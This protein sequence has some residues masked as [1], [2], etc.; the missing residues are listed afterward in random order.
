MLNR[1][2]MLALLGIAPLAAR[3]ASATG[4]RSVIV[5]GAGL[6]GLTAA[7]ALAT[8]GHRVTVVEARDRIGG[9][10]HTSR[11]WR[12]LPMDM[13]ASWIHGT[14][15]NPLTMLADAAGARRAATSYDRATAFG[16][17]GRE[18]DLDPAMTR[19]EHL[20]ETA[21][22]AAG[23]GD[24]LASAV[25]ATQGWRKADASERRLIRH[26]VN[27]NLELEYGCD[28]SEASAW[29]IDDIKEFR[30]NDVVFPDGF[31]AIPRH[32]ARGLDI[33]TGLPVAGLSP[34][35]QGIELRLK[36]GT[37]MT[38]DHAVVT[39][40]LGVLQSGSIAFG[41]ALKGDRQRALS[42]L[43]MGTLNKCWLRF[44]RTAWPEDVDWIEWLGPEDGAWAQWLSLT[45]VAGA[46]VLLAFHGGA[47]ARQIEGRTDDAIRAEA[48]DALR[49][50]FGTRFPA[51][52]AAQISRWSRDP[53]SFGAYSFNATGCTPATRRALA[54][55]DWGGRLV[56][57]GE[58]CEPH[59]HGTAHG[60][61][62]SGRA[63]ARS[64]PA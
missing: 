61:V 41:E 8:A 58:A 57:A 62:L 32:M 21:V 34:R 55:T 37:S 46:P 45:R 4:G 31:D 24:D 7:Q 63:A 1:R 33:R 6:A 36:D 16:P 52:R 42:L 14:R 56:F 59:Y 54:G 11:L 5:V 18:R 60:A 47:K 26:Y 50:M 19:A 27:A 43:K 48:H 29:H 38:A 28:W 15:G 13:G 12:G 39:V 35:G 17:K 9:R 2:S 25:R 20:V 53:L 64:I 10:I 30:G 3:P 49:A 40:P 23:A 22:E 44:D 51:P